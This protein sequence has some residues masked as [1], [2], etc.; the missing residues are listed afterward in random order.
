MCTSNFEKCCFKW[1]A[2]IQQD[3][4]RHV[5]PFP[6][7][8]ILGP[9][10]WHGGQFFS[11]PQTKV[12]VKNSTS[13]PFLSLLF[14]VFVLFLIQNQWE[15]L[16]PLVFLIPR[17]NSI[18]QPYISM[19]GFYQALQQCDDFLSLFPATLHI[20]LHP[21]MLL[22]TKSNP[23]LPFMLSEP[24]MAPLLISGFG[25]QILT[26]LGQSWVDLPTWTEAFELKKQAGHSFEWAF[27]QAV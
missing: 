27:D 19:T 6:D 10:A 14:F 8:A 9:Q 20:S 23:S 21:P 7:A 2:K 18:C 11:V 4:H 25:V 15:K 24:P 17:R 13:E 16:N 26:R 1:D 3:H 12:T 22:L 5:V